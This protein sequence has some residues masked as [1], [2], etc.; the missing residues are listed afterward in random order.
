MDCMLFVALQVSNSLLLFPRTVHRPLSD[1]K[2]LILFAGVELP[3]MLRLAGFL[4]S[5]GSLQR[6]Q[7][8][9]LGLHIPGLR[10][11]R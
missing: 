10:Q 4:W 1:R 11:D 8:C 2:E 6:L 5:C 9:V 7:P 3:E